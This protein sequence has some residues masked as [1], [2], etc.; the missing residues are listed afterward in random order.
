MA[1]R[2]WSHPACTSAA[3][4]PDPSL[5]CA[6]CA[7]VPPDLWHDHS[8]RR[9]RHPGLAACDPAGRRGAAPAAARTARAASQ[10]SQGSGAG[11]YS[12]GDQAL[13]T[14]AAPP[15]SYT[16]RGAVRADDCA[17]CDRNQDRGRLD[18]RCFFH[19]MNPWGGGSSSSSTTRPRPRVEVSP[20]R[21]RPQPP[22]PGGRDGSRA[23][24]A[25]AEAAAADASERAR[26]LRESRNADIAGRAEAYRRSRAT[27]RSEEDALLEVY[28]RNAD[29]D[30][31]SGDDSDDELRMLVGGM[32]R[33]FQAAAAAPPND[34][35][36]DDEEERN[37]AAGG[38]GGAPLHGTDDEEDDDDGNDDEGA[39]GGGGALRHRMDED[40]EE[41]AAGGGGGGEAYQRGLRQANRECPTDEEDE[42]EVE[43]EF[44]GAPHAPPV[45]SNRPARR[46]DIDGMSA[47]LLPAPSDV[48]HMDKR[49]PHCQAWLW[50]GE[51]NK[52][53]ADK[54]ARCCKHGAVPRPTYIAPPKEISDLIEKKSPLSEDFITN[55]RK[56]NQGVGFA[57]T[58]VHNA[59]LGGPMSDF[60]IQGQAA[61]RIGAASAANDTGAKFAQVLFTDGTEAAQINLM[62]AR[63]HLS[64]EK[65]R[66]LL[67]IARTAIITVNP[68]YTIYKTALDR[69]QARVDAGGAPVQD[70]RIVFPEQRN[71]VPQGA[72]AGAFNLNNVG[73][74][75][76]NSEVG[77]IWAVQGDGDNGARSVIVHLKNQGSL[78]EAF[79]CA[80]TTAS[81]RSPHFVCPPLPPFWP[82]SLHLHRDGKWPDEAPAPTHHAPPRGAS[83]VPAALPSR[84]AWLGAPK[85]SLQHACPAAA[86]STGAP[87]RDGPRVLQVPPLR[88]P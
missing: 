46:H 11:S 53:G 35:D 51:L 26:L 2:C 8:Q 57:S 42:D 16:E 6:A 80:A 75:A 73:G 78:P 77:A 56:I 61:F 4:S 14:W 49:C 55:A 76:A 12:E 33:E 36:T 40:E 72:H 88:A 48:G 47:A 39:A 87:V 82:F 18:W 10:A 3:G 50:P 5:F 28:G 44:G 34:M 84:R 64:T 43:A 81:A 27:G 70:Y 58:V 71:A 9:R 85:H 29:G 45:F 38:G 66:Q 20:E 60:R 86:R 54:F 13:R 74:A 15:P 59:T 30:D 21:R 67:F 79:F 17:E 65:H 41:G 1:P 62:L 31:G 68:F 23:A 22:R 83:H 7:V 19:A 24:A 37:S 52:F 69:E 63:T 32:E 25:A